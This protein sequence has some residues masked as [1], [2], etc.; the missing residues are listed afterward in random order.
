MFGN[1]VI[2]SSQGN[3]QIKIHL[4]FQFLYK[5]GK[6]MIKHH[7]VWARKTRLWFLSSSGIKFMFA[8]E[9]K[10]LNKVLPANP[11]LNQLFQFLSKNKRR[12]INHGARLQE[13][14]ICLAH[15]IIQIGKDL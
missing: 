15:R 4:T 8:N 2:S 12:K 1:S 6:F 3:P 11:L 5:L 7:V 14:K 10:L 13:K 9:A